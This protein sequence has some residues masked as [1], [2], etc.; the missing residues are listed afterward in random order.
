M[1][2]STERTHVTLDVTEREPLKLSWRTPVS[3]ESNYH[4]RL[5]RLRNASVE[6]RAC[7][8]NLIT[9]AMTNR[10]ANQ[11]L[12][13]GSQLKK[14]AEA[15]HRLREAI[16]SSVPGSPDEEEADRT[17]RE[18]LPN[19]NN[20]EIHVRVPPDVFVPWGLAYDADPS[21]LSGNPD[22]IA[23]STYSEFWCLKYHLSTLY[24]KIPDRIVIKPTRTLDARIVSLRHQDAWTKAF[25]DVPDEEKEAVKLLFQSTPPICSAEEFRNFWVR[26]KKRFETD[27][28]YFFGHASG[29][30]LEFKKGDILKLADF[31]DMFLRR[32]PTMYPA[33]LVFLNGCHTAVG[34]DDNGGFMQAT[35][36]LGYCGFIG[37]EA[38]VPDVFALRFANA[39]LARLLYTGAKV[40][41][42][43]DELRRDFWPL[44]LA[45]NLSCHP[46]FR[47]VTTDSGS[48][49][50]MK[51]PDFSQDPI[52]SER[53]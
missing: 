6:A 8:E 16:F 23:M 22:D 53:M 36:V 9:E 38:K 47:F 5:Q 52:G 14:L 35:A 12:R 34:D 44:S 33:C 29:A 7:L 31:P 13:V 43:M 27:L 50:S 32:P 26:D 30:A 17:G 20:V 19:L 51:L 46:E 41:A 40:R 4:V 39:F 21:E 11:P 15:G 45:Y 25:K 48:A 10:A 18:W 24:N 49:P 1:T 28:L 42:V 3:D 37:T 2:D